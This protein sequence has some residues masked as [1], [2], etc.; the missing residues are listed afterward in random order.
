VPEVRGSPPNKK[1]VFGGLLCHAKN[2]S[3]SKSVFS[4]EGFFLHT[5]SAF[6]LHISCRGWVGNLLK[7]SP[8]AYGGFAP[9][10]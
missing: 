6:Y 3:P 8:S 7:K 1:T 5:G 9:C 10:K 2:K 4:L